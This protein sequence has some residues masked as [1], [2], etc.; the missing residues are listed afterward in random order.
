MD[1]G[2]EGGRERRGEERRGEERRGFGGCCLSMGR[3]RS[4]FILEGWAF[5]RFDIESLAFGE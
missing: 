3:V 5:V 1:G 4:R 2:R